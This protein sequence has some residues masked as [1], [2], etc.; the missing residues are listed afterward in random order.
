[1]TQ[2]DLLPTA[3]ADLFAQ[4][5]AQGYITTADRYGLLAALLDDDS[6]SEEEKTAIN[7][8]LW[9]VA[10]KRIAIVEQ[11]SMTEN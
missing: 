11:I 9:A 3:L 7:R 2:L 1:M 6:L 8:L 5:S 10:K 4:V